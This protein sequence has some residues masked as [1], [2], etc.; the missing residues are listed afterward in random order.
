MT[1]IQFIDELADVPELAFSPG[2]TDTEFDQTILK[3]VQYVQRR[4]R[5]TITA[6]KAKRDRRSIRLARIFP[7][8]A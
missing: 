8:P 3:R 6:A 7:S 5:P 1:Q 2:M 4:D